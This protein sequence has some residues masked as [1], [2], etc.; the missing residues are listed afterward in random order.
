MKMT[1]LCDLLRIKIFHRPSGDD[2][3]YLRDGGGDRGLK[4]ADWAL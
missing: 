1:A 4:M 2:L 3:D